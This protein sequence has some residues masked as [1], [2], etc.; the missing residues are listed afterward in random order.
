[1]CKISK[2]LV[3]GVTNFFSFF[4]VF[5]LREQDNNAQA[6]KLVTGCNEVNGCN[7]V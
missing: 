3:S 6:V 2:Q 5:F 4:S 7:R 1:M